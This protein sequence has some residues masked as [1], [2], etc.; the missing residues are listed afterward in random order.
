MITTR[1]NRAT[2][3]NRVCATGRESFGLIA[4]SAAKA[5]TITAMISHVSQV[6]TLRKAYVAPDL[7]GQ[8]FLSY[9]GAGVTARSGCSLK[10]TIFDSAHK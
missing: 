1:T 8:P 5:A 7:R 9:C 3:I 2:P 6:T 4:V 10:F